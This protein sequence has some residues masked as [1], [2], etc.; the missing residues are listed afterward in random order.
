ML[1]DAPSLDR[2]HSLAASVVAALERGPREG[3]KE[4]SCRRM[5]STLLAHLNA[6]PR[7][8]IF[9][10]DL[11]G[12]FEKYWGRGHP[13]ILAAPAARG[14]LRANEATLVA[15]S[16]LLAD[17]SPRNTALAAAVFCV[18]GDLQA[19]WESSERGMCFHGLEGFGVTAAVWKAV[20]AQ[21]EGA[22]ALSL[23]SYVVASKTDIGAIRRSALFGTALIGSLLGERRAALAAVN[24]LLEEEPQAVSASYDQCR[25]SFLL[26]LGADQTNAAMQRLQAL[27]APFGSDRSVLHHQL[28]EPV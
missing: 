5:R 11:Q 6:H 12:R 24:Q 10:R 16:L 20:V 19:S 2:P 25:E 28:L 9:V 14:R 15:N 3:S 1:T 8:P 22:H 4:L 7:T 17:R 21:A 18:E 13:T 26:R 23:Q 27:L